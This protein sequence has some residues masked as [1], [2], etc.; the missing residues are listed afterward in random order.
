[1]EITKQQ[2]K[3]FS[4]N[5]TKNPLTG[6]SIQVGKGTHQ[7]LLEACLKYNSPSKNSHRSTSSKTPSPQNS[8]SQE[9][10]PMGP[11]IHWMIKDYS[12]REE[13]MVEMLEYI[14]QRITTLETYT[15][16]SEME[17]NEILDIL[18]EAKSI[19]KGMTDFENNINIDSIRIKKLIKS[20]EIIH[21]LPKNK[22]IK[23]CWLEVT[24]D[25]LSIRTNILATLLP[26]QRK[27]N[28]MK[29]MIKANKIDTD[30]SS[31]E[32]EMIV[33]RKVYLDYLI[34]HHIFTYDDIYKHTFSSEDDFKE[35]QRVFKEYSKLYKK[36]K[37][38]SP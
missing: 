17:S 26:L 29:A 28:N 18:K 2:C 37:G 31:R 1:M 15:K 24:Q 6:R 25:R 13:M 32:I 33:N 23:E 10:P 22:L 36:I 11:I 38:H 8:S 21:D 4:Q 14:D 34:E 5:P 3:E 27:I 9:A 35:L 16:L 12:K 20:K 19:F 7:K 30:Y